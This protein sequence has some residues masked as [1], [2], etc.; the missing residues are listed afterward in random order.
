VTYYILIQRHS[1]CG[2]SPVSMSLTPGDFINNIYYK[3]RRTAM[4]QLWV[5]LAAT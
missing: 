1:T 2:I 5:L 3:V 4:S